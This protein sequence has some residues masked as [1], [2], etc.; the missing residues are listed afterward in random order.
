MKIIQYTKY[1]LILLSMVPFC[2]HPMKR[3]IKN[4]KNLIIFVTKQNQKQLLH[5][6]GIGMLYNFYNEHLSLSERALHKLKELSASQLQKLITEHAS[7]DL[8]NEFITHTTGLYAK[9]NNNK[10]LLCLKQ[11]EKEAFASLAHRL[12]KVF[13]ALE[14]KQQTN[15]ESFESELFN[16]FYDNVGNTDNKKIINEEEEEELKIEKKVIKSGPPSPSIYIPLRKDKK[17]G[18]SPIK[19]INIE[20]GEELKFTPLVMTQ[21][22]ILSTN[23]N[24]EHQEKVEN[25]TEKDLQTIETHGIAIIKEQDEK[26]LVGNPYEKLKYQKK[27]NYVIDDGNWSPFDKNN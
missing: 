4:K 24:W 2:M 10:Q 8:Y 16:C 11:D 15:E 26:N 19:I 12:L 20:E 3:N 14:P 17:E 6:H 9:K 23:V 25:L 13:T 22:N 7:E 27:Y 1:L 18:Y 21:K 5:T